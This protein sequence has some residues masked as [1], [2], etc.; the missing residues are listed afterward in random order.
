M[1]DAEA[2]V[3]AERPPA[4]APGGRPDVMVVRL[5]DRGD[6]L[7][8]EEFEGEATLIWGGSVLRLPT[9]ADLRLSAAVRLLAGLSAAFEAF[10]PAEDPAPI[11]TAEEAEGTEREGEE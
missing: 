5:L 6:W 10:P 9:V 8:R 4:E 11:V 2:G 1:F 3:E 7:P